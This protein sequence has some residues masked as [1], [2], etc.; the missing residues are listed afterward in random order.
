M[1]GTWKGTTA[2]FGLLLAAVTLLP[3][4]AYAALSPLY[5]SLREIETI[6]HD[7]RLADAFANQQA[8]V[9]ITSPATDTYELRTESCTVTVEVIDVPAEAGKPMIIGPR[10]FT[11]EFGQVQCQ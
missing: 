6:L 8:V 9:S 10:Q 3:L 7:P 4:P 2:A 1:S 11:L 5:Q